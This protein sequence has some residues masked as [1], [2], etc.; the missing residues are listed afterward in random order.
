MRAYLL[1]GRSIADKQ[2]RIS[3]STSFRC[4]SF[5]D[6]ISVKTENP[7]SQRYED[8][9]S[10]KLLIAFMLKS[11]DWYRIEIQNAGNS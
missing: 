8:S 4:F 3:F 6:L 2:M 1:K 5:F 7:T 9:N 10:R 11:G